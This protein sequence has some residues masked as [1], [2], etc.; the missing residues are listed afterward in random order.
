MSASITAQRRVALGSRRAPSAQ[1]WLRSDRRV[2]VA[3]LVPAFAVFA[4]FVSVQTTR[5]LVW[6]S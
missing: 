3:L 5:L 6:M 4:V 2:G 1:S